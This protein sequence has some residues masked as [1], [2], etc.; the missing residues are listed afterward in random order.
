M[1]I[2]RAKILEIR[3]TSAG[4]RT[5]L[6]SWPGGSLP[7]AGQYLQ[8]HRPQDEDAPAPVS[9]FAGGWS[10]DA[11]PADTF[12][13]APYIPLAWQP[14]D[15]LLL[16]GPLGRGFALPAQARRVALGVLDGYSDVLLPLLEEVFARD[17][18]A[19]LFTAGDFPAFPASVE[20]SPLQDLPDAFGWADYIALS[21]SLE[22]VAQAQNTLFN[23]A[24]KCPVQVL[25]HTE[26]PCGGMAQCGVCALIG[27][28]RKI[29]LPC[30]DGPVF[31]VGEL[32]N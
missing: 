15:T 18:E 12:T 22:A 23:L 8:A 9:L 2:A 26:M 14:G 7:K 16:R 24:A 13:T 27:K 5:A 25:A 3:Q 30:E 21:G 6:L 11:L 10:R 28:R 20:V 19:A 31:D 1:H 32:R 17:G 29:L 4:V